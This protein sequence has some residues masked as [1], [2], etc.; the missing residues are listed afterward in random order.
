MHDRYGLTTRGYRIICSLCGAEWEYTTSK[1]RDLV[2]GGVFAAIVRT[3]KITDDKSIWIL[4][5]TGDNKDA[6]VFLD[7]EISL[8]EWKQMVASFC[9][10]C[11]AQLAKEEK[12]CPKCGAG[13][14]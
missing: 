3:A 4:Q 1:P 5:K 7:K 11:G 8:S 14:D 2:I 13:R 6:E 9:G 12:F 10:K